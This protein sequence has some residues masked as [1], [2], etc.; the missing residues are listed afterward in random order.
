MRWVFALFLV[1]GMLALI[2][3]AMVGGARSRLSG[4]D[5]SVRV[6]Q[7]VAAAVAFGMGGL[8]ASYA[9][10]SLWLATVAALVAAALAAWYANRVGGAGGEDGG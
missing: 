3:W 5:R 4:N 6:Q 8:S 2:A 7:G 10:W 9:G 1:G